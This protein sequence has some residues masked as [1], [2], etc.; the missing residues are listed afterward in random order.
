VQPESSDIPKELL[1]AIESIDAF[2]N[3]LPK[4]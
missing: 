4:G 3:A 1:K 2:L